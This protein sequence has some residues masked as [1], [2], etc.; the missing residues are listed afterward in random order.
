[1]TSL[2]FVRHA[3][4]D[5]AWEDDRTRPLTEDGLADREK[6]TLCLE[7][8]QADVFISSPYKRS[9][10]TIRD[11]AACKG[12]S[13]E[14]D[15][16]LVER[17]NGPLSNEFGMFHKRWADFDYCEE[18]GEPIGRVQKRNVEAILDILKTYEGKS[19]VIGTH[20][21]ALSA[22]QN[23]FDPDFR[24]DDFLRIID[25]M[26]YILRMDFEGTELVGKDELLIVK[27]KFTGALR[28]DRLP[29]R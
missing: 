20:G 2:Y 24:C 1:M 14:T 17:K 4:P 19:V 27:K 12:L 23:W 11:C 29:E 5:H 3:E 8:V 16:R 7:R 22:I 10:D 18:D 6:V 28:A 13:I 15:E 9:W 25:F 26:P 21:T